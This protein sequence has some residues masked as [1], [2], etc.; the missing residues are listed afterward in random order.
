[1]F[2]RSQYAKI[3]MGILVVTVLV[4][5]VGLVMAQSDEARTTVDLAFVNHI[6]AGLPEQDVHFLTEDGLA[7]R[8]DVIH[9]MSVLYQNMVGVTE[10]YPQDP[11]RISDAPLGP[12]EAG[13]D[14]GFTAMEWLAG[15]GTGTYYAN[16]TT[17]SLELSFENLLPNAVYSIWCTRVT[18]PP[19]FTV[20]HTACGLIDGSDGVFTTDAEGNGAI[21]ITEVSPLEP[22]SDTARSAITVFYHSDGM[23]HGYTPGEYGVN[24]HFQLLSMLPAPAN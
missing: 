21:T 2:A 5:G 7:M 16:H 13:E 15:T 3:S 11:F 17:A 4:L 14:L 10:S 19:E 22:S 12:Y 24:T 20:T 23:T 8:L 18:L 9:P 1:M 6:Q